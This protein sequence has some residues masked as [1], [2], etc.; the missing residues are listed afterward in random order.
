MTHSPRHSRAGLKNVPMV[1][2]LS[3]TITAIRL[4][5]VASFFVSPIFAS[6]LAS[7]SQQVDQIFSAYDDTTPGCA[8]AIDRNNEYLHLAGYGIADLEQGV[9][10]QPE[11]V[12]YAASVSKQFVAMSA[13]ILEQQGKLA[14][15][16]PIRDYLTELPVYA[17]RVT[18]RDLLSHTGGIRDYFNLFALGGRLE[19]LVI[20][21][22]KIM[23][24]LAMQEGL[25][26]EPG[27]KYAYSNSAYFLV[28]QIVK[29]T[30]GRN[31]NDF[32]QEH[33][34][35]P[36]DLS[37][38]RFQHNHRGL[39]PG[40]AH[41]YEPIDAGGY[42]LSDSRLDVVGSG[43]MYTTVINLTKWARNFRNNKLLGGSA[44]V[45]AMETPGELNSGEK[46]D[47]GLGIKV[48]P[49]GG[50]KTHAHGGSLAGY[51]NYLMHFPDQKFS[52]AILCNDQNSNPGEF[53]NAIAEIYLADEFIAERKA[54]EDRHI[55]SKEPAKS[56]QTSMTDLA[57]YQGE[58]FGKEVDGYLTI[59]AVEDSLAMDFRTEL[60]RVTEVANDQFRSD[61]YGFDLVF[62]RD[63]GDDIVG[64]TFNGS[65]AAG[66]FFRRQ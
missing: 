4:I 55:P 25:S 13:L 28:S 40:K 31:L 36:L 42:L 39:I 47:Y 51:R 61:E 32:A 10:I 6:E 62:S 35:V 45:K 7:Q 29:A 5:V 3:R 64:F 9:P 12:F 46:T 22:D 20:T 37:N 33:I 56:P 65:R 14:L 1:A 11:S 41:G 44:T 30:D 52:I 26:F 50:L 60:V 34:F 18:T 66:I 49:Y 54:D 2:R 17:D 27:E 21:E 24:V 23:D 58:Y 8:V 38:S 48:A 16:Q 15:D 57:K 63:E 59:E 53:A 43:G 19:G